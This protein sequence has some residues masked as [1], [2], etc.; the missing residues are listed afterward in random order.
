MFSETSMILK[1]INIVYLFVDIFGG[2]VF[3]YR[4]H[5]IHAIFL[6]VIMKYEWW[7][8][9]SL[10]LCISGFWWI[11][12]I[13]ITFSFFFWNVTQK[14]RFSTKLKGMH[15]L[16]HALLL[17]NVACR[18][19]VCASWNVCETLHNDNTVGHHLGQRSYSMI[20]IC[21]CCPS[22]NNY[23]ESCMNFVERKCLLS[24]RTH[25]FFSIEINLRNNF[26]INE[27]KND[28][29]SDHRFRTGPGENLIISRCLIQAG[30]GWSIINRLIAN[31][32]PSNSR[33][34]PI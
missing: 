14:K 28:I 8:L 29:F 21:L 1:S 2:G 27:Q 15:S 32:K 16:H 31:F 12:E 26:L 23:P 25:S 34:L 22:T 20:K 33:R 11:E 13:M 19:N 30:E 17:S 5:S 10:K 9:S 18:R 24:K 4:V 3:D 6:W 7:F